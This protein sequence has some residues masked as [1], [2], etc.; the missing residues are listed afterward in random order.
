MVARRS[1]G[2]TLGDD[3][4][5][6]QYEPPN[7][8][9]IGSAGSAANPALGSPETVTSGEELAEGLWIFV[10]S[11]GTAELINSDGTATAPDDGSAYPLT[12]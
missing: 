3:G 5:I 11:S 9:V 7:L 6:Y 2:I 10:T 12:F 1:A 8:I 4:N